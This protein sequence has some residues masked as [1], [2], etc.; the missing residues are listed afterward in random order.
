MPIPDTLQ[1]SPERADSVDTISGRVGARPWNDGTPIT[2]NARDYSQDEIGNST[3]AGLFT[4]IRSVDI[5]FRTVDNIN[6]LIDSLI[7]KIVT[8]HFSAPRLKIRVNN[9]DTYDIGLFYRVSSA[10][11]QKLPDLNGWFID[12]DG[13]PTTTTTDD[14]SFIG[15]LISR[16][17]DIRRQ[18]YELELLLLNYRT[19]KLAKLRSP[20]GE[21]LELQESNRQIIF[22]NTAFSDNDAAKFFVGDVVEVFKPDWTLRSGTIGAPNSATV[23]SVG[24]DY[25]IIDVAFTTTPLEGDIIEIARLGEYP[26][27]GNPNGPTDCDLGYTYAGASG[28]VGPSAAEAHIYSDDGL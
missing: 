1:W 6:D 21:V 19:G 2:V 7:S 20:S 22:C 8:L 18:V 11:V 5:D 9:A 14:F 28:T 3:R 24:S 15:M 10:D 13:N 4:Q 17:F 25:I 26:E 27:N 23:T 12:K 16:Q